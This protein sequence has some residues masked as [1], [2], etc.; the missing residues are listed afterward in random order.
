[1]TTLILCSLSACF[2]FTL[3]ILIVKRD[4]IWMQQRI[5][6]LEAAND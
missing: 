4:T 1:M 2:G 5:N 3:A 6:K